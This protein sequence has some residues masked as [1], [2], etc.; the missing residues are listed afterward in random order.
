VQ[1]DRVKRV[2]NN[3][4]GKSRSKVT[5][6]DPQPEE[7]RLKAA[8]ECDKVKRVKYNNYNEQGKPKFKQ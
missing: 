6:C 8:E 4:N 5:Q 7:N 3:N 2:K 1:C